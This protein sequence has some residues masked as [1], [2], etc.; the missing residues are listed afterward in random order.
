MTITVAT[1]RSISIFCDINDN[2]YVMKTML[3]KQLAQSDLLA[4][5]SFEAVHVRQKYSVEHFVK[6][7][8]WQVS[9]SLKKAKLW[10]EWFSKISE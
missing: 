7:I 2:K 9:W 5:N 3:C 4:L 10:M 1:I 6:K 8:V